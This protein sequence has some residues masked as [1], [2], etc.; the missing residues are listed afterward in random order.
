M[1]AATARR[2]WASQLLIPCD[3]FDAFIDRGLD[4]C[5][6]R[7]IPQE[8]FAD[9]EFGVELPL[10]P[11]YRLWQAPRPKRIS[12]ATCSTAAA[13][14]FDITVQLVHRS[15]ATQSEA[16]RQRR[17]ARRS[18]QPGNVL[19]MPAICHQ[20]P[21]SAAREADEPA[22]ATI[23]WPSRAEVSPARESFCPRSSKCRPPRL[24]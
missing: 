13:H 10:S 12:D 20:R 14:P 19:T 21:V 1:G 24:F 22:L 5:L 11:R 16:G 9:I 6:Q 2:Q 8:F 18:P 7:R 4:R 17:A 23:Q 15:K 3:D